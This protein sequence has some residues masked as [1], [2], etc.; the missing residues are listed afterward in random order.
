V[1]H[2]T[3]RDLRCVLRS[4][5]RRALRECPRWDVYRILASYPVASSAQLSNPEAA[6]DERIGSSRRARS[7]PL[8][9]LVQDRFTDVHAAWEDRFAH[10]PMVTGPP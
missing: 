7:S 5:S 6:W 4:R 9:R 1:C 8:F 2:E 10:T 3:L